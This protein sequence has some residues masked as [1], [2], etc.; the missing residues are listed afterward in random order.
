MPAPVLKSFAK[1][2]GKSIE[3]LERFWNE[4]KKAATEK[5]LEKDSPQFFAFVTAIVKKRAGLDESLEE[6]WGWV[7]D[8]IL[9]EQEEEEIVAEVPPGAAPSEEDDVD[10]PPKNDKGETLLAQFARKKGM[11]EFQIE[12]IWNNVKIRGEIWQIENKATDKETIEHSMKV[13]QEVM[14]LIPDAPPEPEP[15][16]GEEGVPVAAPGE[17]EAPPGKGTP[18]KNVAASEEGEQKPKDV[19]AKEEKAQDKEE[20]K[21]KAK[22]E[23]DRE[24]RDKQDDK[25]EEDTKEKAKAKKE[26]KKESMEKT[27]LA[28]E[29]AGSD[30]RI[31][32]NIISAK[33]RQLLKKFG[34]LD[35]DLLGLDNKGIKAF[36]KEIKKRN[37][38]R[39]KITASKKKKGLGFLGSIFVGAAGFGAG[40]LA[41]K[42]LDKAFSVFATGQKT[43]GPAFKDF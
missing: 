12:Q 31:G 34:I 41:S 18:P 6:F 8:T 27:E 30:Q 5:G 25:N 37:L 24:V 14:A 32:G 28:L 26:A 23:K 42:A 3:E 11:S 35:K 29:A 1:K 38:K 16:E 43:T 15:E 21:D 19:D 10:K 4:A 9:N 7:L 33:D 17:K 2:S 36:V 20:K 39:A 13:F 40:F 22:G